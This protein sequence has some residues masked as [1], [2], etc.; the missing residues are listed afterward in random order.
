MYQ[1]I[2]IT[3]IRN[4]KANKRNLEAQGESLP[5]TTEY[6]ALRP[7]FAHEAVRAI[8]LLQCYCYR[9][10]VFIIC[11]FSIIAYSVFVI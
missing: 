5:Y 3:A 11:L 10:I 2:T 4:E 1:T 7:T 8:M 9:F 6:E